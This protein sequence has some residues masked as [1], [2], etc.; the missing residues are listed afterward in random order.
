MGIAPRGTGGTLKRVVVYSNTDLPGGNFVNIDVKSVLPHVY[1]RLTVDNFGVLYAGVYVYAN[2]LE[3]GV[4]VN[5]YDQ[6]SGILNVTSAQPG[7]T[8]SSTRIFRL[9]VACWYE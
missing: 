6:E 1:K 4:R 2:T 5:T 3:E 7:G 8:S 9:I